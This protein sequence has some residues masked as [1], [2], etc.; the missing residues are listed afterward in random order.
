MGSSFRITDQTF[1]QWTTL[2]GG[3]LSFL[4]STWEGITLSKWIVVNFECHCILLFTIHLVLTIT[5]LSPLAILHLL[6]FTFSSPN[7][8]VKIQPIDNNIYPT[9]TNSRRLSHFSYCTSILLYLL[10]PPFFFWSFVFLELHPQHLEVP[11]LELELQLQLLAYA[12]ATATPDPRHI[13]NLYH[14]SW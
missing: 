7:R 13:C 4:C 10:F 1:R 5:A 2:G 9:T 3:S 14:S 11:R 6:S 8:L 12:I